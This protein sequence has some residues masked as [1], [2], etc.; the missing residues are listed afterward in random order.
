MRWLQCSSAGGGDCSGDPPSARSGHSAVVVS[1]SSSSAAAP[2]LVVFGGLLEKNFLGDVVVL[3]AGSPARWFRPECSGSR[4]PLSEEEGGH[5]GPG[6]GPRA[7][8]AAAAIDCNVFIFGGRSGK[9][10]LGDF[11]MLDTD[12]WQWIELSAY[13]EHPPPRDFASLTAIGNGRLVLFGGG[14]G[15]KWLSDVYVLDTMSL[16]WRSLPIGSVSAGIPSPRC[17]HSALMVEK[18]LLV[19]GGRGAGGQITGDLWALKGL[20][21]EGTPPPPAS[22]T[23]LRLAGAAP[24]PRCGHTWTALGTQVIV[25]GGHGTAGWITRQDVYHNDCTVLDRATVSWRKLNSSHRALPPPRAYHTMTR[26]DRRLLLIGGFDGKSTLGD[27]WWLLPDD[28]PLAKKAADEEAVALSLAAAKPAAAPV[29]RAGGGEDRQAAS[30]DTDA[31]DD[32]EG[33]EEEEDMQALAALRSRMDLPQGSPEVPRPPANAHGLDDPGLLHL[34]LRLLASQE[35]TPTSGSTGTATLASRSAI[36]AVMAARAHLSNLAANELPL[37]DLPVML[38]D[39]RRLI[40][41]D[42]GLLKKDDSSSPQS[43]RFFHVRSI[44]DIRLGDVSALQGEYRRLLLA[45]DP[46]RAS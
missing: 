37:K 17:S 42:Q 27:T 7:F 1:S 12:T 24:S 28:D 2:R 21:E 44:Q 41:C 45:Q 29:E 6:P 3:E 40:A 14:D 34:G 31:F 26:L 4:S 10:R 35:T 32:S 39:Y 16:E 19:L 43:F 20:F 8:H 15:N 30:G 46:L 18:R 13:G 5:A 38:S 33:E 23:Q 11:W 36:P 25:F 9:R 22:W